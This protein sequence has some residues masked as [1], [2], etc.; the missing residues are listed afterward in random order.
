M[1]ADIVAIEGK[2]ARSEEEK[3]QLEAHYTSNVKLLGSVPIAAGIYAVAYQSNGQAV[4][5]AGEDGRVRVID[6]ATA[7]ITKEF[8][9]VPIGAAAAAAVAQAAK[10]ESK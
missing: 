6:A 10:L 1:P 8:I 5:A 3:K 4:A 7:K 9:P 2:A